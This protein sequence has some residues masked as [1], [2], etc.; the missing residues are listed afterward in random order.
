MPSTEE[1]RLDKPERAPPPPM[2]SLYRKSSQGPNSL[3]GVVVSDKMHT[4]Q[5]PLE[6]TLT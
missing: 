2:T 1:I 5:D 6:T 4:Q 3:P